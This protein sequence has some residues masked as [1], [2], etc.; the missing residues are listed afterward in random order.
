MGPGFFPAVT[1]ELTSLRTLGHHPNIV[2]LLEM[3]TLG[4]VPSDLSVV[5]VFSEWGYTFL[6]FLSNPLTNSRMESNPVIPLMVMKQLLTGVQYIHRNR[7]IH[8]NLTGSSVKI[9]LDGLVRIGSFNYAIPEGIGLRA[10][11][12]P[13]E[14][15]PL[16][17][18][19]TYDH[20][21]PE[22]IFGRYGDLS[23]IPDCKPLN[24]VTGE[25]WTGKPEGFRI[26]L[27]AV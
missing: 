1:K 4:S 7:I 2:H 19:D 23:V 18:P 27:T 16:T 17:K 13:N 21:A 26:V 12:F 9:G 14:D 25:L 22:I 6:E 24:R 20:L 5:F 3:Y 15:F 11:P 10:A 8:R